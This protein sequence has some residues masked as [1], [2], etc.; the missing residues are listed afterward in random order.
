VLPHVT[1]LVPISQDETGEK[2]SIQLYNKYTEIRYFDV[3]LSCVREMANQLI[4]YQCGHDSHKPFFAFPEFCGGE[5][6]VMQGFASAI[7]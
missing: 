6:G 5:L 1:T 3:T 2:S 4:A 7:S